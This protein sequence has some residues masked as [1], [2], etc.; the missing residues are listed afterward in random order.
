[1]LRAVMFAG[2]PVAVLV[3]IYVLHDPFKVLRWHDEPFADHLGLNKGTL[4]VSSFERFNP[5][6]HFDSFI[7]GASVSCYYRVDEWRQYLPDS[8]CVTHFDS[9]WQPPTHL[10]RFVE[11]L[12]RKDVPMHHVLLVLAPEVFTFVDDADNIS[13]LLP[14]A[15]VPCTLWPE[16]PSPLHAL[17]FHYKFFTSFCSYR[18]LRPYGHWKRTGERD[19]SD[20]TYIFD[21]QPVVYRHVVNEES[22]P[23]WD[24]ML[25]TDA[26]AFHT[27]KGLKKFHAPGDVYTPLP[28]G[29]KPEYR[30][31]LRRVADVLRKRHADVKIILAPSPALYVLTPD[32]EAFM[33]QTFGTLHCSA[34]RPYVNLTREFRPEQS[35]PSNFYDGIHYRPS[36]A[37]KYLRRAYSPPYGPFPADFE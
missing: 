28:G 16:I 1:M 11:F 31:A 34:G 29:I 17:R 35:D 8:A 21:P 30:D 37:S 15:V 33:Q 3:F 25:D 24:Y 18:Y 6:H 10:A 5:E 7:I 27:P 26:A 23:E 19:E 13:T 2:L 20:G 22:I 9:S 12:D 32:D 4:S 36:L 14:P